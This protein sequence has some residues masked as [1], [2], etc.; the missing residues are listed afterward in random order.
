MDEIWISF[1]L[2]AVHARGRHLFLFFMVLE[3]K[4]PMFLF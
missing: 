3:E 4:A 1:S 2:V